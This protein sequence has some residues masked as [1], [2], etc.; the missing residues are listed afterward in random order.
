MKVVYVPAHLYLGTWVD[1]RLFVE[2][3]E[4]TLAGTE[5]VPACEFKQWVISSPEEL[6]SIVTN[7]VIHDLAAFQVEVDFDGRCLLEISNCESV[8]EAGEVNWHQVE[9]A[10]GVLKIFYLSRIPLTD[11]IRNMLDRVIQIVPR[12][13]PEIHQGGRLEPKEEDISY[14]LSPAPAPVMDGETEPPAA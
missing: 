3:A 4:E 13:E 11:K 9:D 2:L 8:G 5:I 1:R 14:D 6:D 12:D 10:D 7:I